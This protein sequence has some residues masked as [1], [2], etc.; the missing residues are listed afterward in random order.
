MTEPKLVDKKVLGDAFGLIFNGLLRKLLIADGLSA[1]VPDAFLLDGNPSWLALITYAIIIYN[2]FSGYTSLV[3]G[4][5]LFF[6]IELSSNFQQPYLARNFSEFWNR[7][8]ISLTAWLRETIYFPLSR[9]INKQKS[10]LSF[11]IKCLSTT[12]SYNACQW[13]M[14]WVCSGDGVLGWICM[15]YFLYSNA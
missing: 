15:V 10:Y 6:G 2:D 14:A 7:W 13:G 11:A 5:S 3:R 12:F 8:H 9:K 1:M 4:V